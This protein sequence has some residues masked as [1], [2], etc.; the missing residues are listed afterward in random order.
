VVFAPN[1]T[2]N[3]ACFGQAN[4]N[5]SV[6]AGFTGFQSPGAFGVSQI[7]SFPTLSVPGLGTLLAC[8]NLSPTSRVESIN[9]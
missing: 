1:I 5:D 9:Y 6:I 2:H 8:C 4:F 3:V 7:L